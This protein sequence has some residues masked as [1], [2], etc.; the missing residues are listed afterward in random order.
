MQETE[1]LDHSQPNIRLIDLY[2]SIKNKY[3]KKIVFFETATHIHLF[4]EDAVLLKRLLKYKVYIL[5]KTN[6]QYIKLSFPLARKKLILQ[7]IKKELN[8]HTIVFTQNKEKTLFIKTA[9][10]SFNS[11]SRKSD[12]INK[13]DVLFLIT[14]FNNEAN[15]KHD[16]TINQLKRGE[17]K[18]FQ[19][20]SKTKELLEAINRAILNFVPK[21]YKILEDKMLSLWLEL[22][23][24]VNSLRV[25][26]N[27]P[28]EL[29]NTLKNIKL[30][31][32]N[33]FVIS[34]KV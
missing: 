16:F 5:G 32:D 17:H 2:N 22:L 15:Q 11:P 6:E 8:I 31:L 19:L 13:D 10:S 21:K 1:I 27:N 33:M 25:C 7:K 29:L 30:T 20:H 3:S 4:N 23:N 12:Y 9:F 18:D 14:D 24:S 34:I 28:D 26:K